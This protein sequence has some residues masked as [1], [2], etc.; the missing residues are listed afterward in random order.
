MATS[1]WHWEQG[2]KF[3]VEGIKTTLL[4]NGAAAIAL[5]TFADKHNISNGMTWALYLFA[6]GTTPSALAFVAAYMAQLQYGNAELPTRTETKF[7]KQ[8]K[9]GLSALLFWCL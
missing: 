9:T 5:V 6:V 4:L 3:A 8:A 1:E 7:G 2:T